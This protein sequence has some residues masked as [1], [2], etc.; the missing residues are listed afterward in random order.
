MKQLV[1]PLKSVPWLIFA[2]LLCGLSLQ[3][4]YAVYRPISTFT[5][6]ELPAPPRVDLVK[7]LS[8]GDSIVSAKLLMLWL[9]SFSV[10]KGQF[11]ANQQLDYDTL[12]AWLKVILALDPLANYPL[13][14]ASH[15]YTDVSDAQKQ[16]KMLEF[17]YSEFFINPSQRW[18]W[19]AYVTVM[20]KHRLKELPLA[21][22]YAQ[23]IAQHAS[24]DTPLWAQEM[25]IFILED[26]KKWEEA[27]RV[28]HDLLLNHQIIDPQELQFLQHKQDE[29][30]AKIKKNITGRDE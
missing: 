12:I 24:R 23:A 2:F 8:L 16:R 13:F 9:Q 17:V 29:L 21:L 20:A 25:Q 27:Q 1:R 14:A 28:V 15:L 30:V 11:L 19:L 7:T 6:H 22:K 10:Q 18:L 3:V 4:I 5:P 26:M